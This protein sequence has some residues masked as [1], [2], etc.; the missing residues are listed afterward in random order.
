MSPEAQ[1]IAI[2]EACGYTNVCMQEWE[3]VDIESRSIAYG[4]ELQGTIN[5]KRCFVD[6]YLND[7]NAMH[8]AEKVLRPMQR[9]RYRT[10]L[11]YILAGADIFA[12]AEQRA[13]AFLKTIGEWK[14]T[15]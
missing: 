6:N 15:K 2:A 9:E 4:T 1:R 7:L 14:D 12:T 10:E 11:V 8:E 3:S 13:E 5:G